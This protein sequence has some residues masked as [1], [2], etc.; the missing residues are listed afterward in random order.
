MPFVFVD[1]C[2]LDFSPFT[3]DTNYYARAGIAQSI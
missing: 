3:V 1:Y 2:W